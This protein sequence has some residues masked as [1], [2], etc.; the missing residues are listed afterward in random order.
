MDKGI[1]L[2]ETLI[3][4]LLFAVL[5]GVMVSLFSIF[6][7]TWPSQET[8]AGLQFDLGW[9]MERMVR[10]LRGTGE[11][12]IKNGNEI[13]FLDPNGGYSIYYF[14][15]KMYIFYDVS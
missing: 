12:K 13:R 1:T 6:P 14:Y 3:V 10:D 8:R 11:F 2:I 5:L 9:A 7:G 4:S 15:Y